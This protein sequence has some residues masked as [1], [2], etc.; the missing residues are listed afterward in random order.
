LELTGA[1]IF[2][3]DKW[4]VSCGRHRNDEF[5]SFTSSS[6]FINAARQDNGQLAEFYTTSSLFAEMSDNDCSNNIFQRRSPIGYGGYN[7]NAS[8]SFL[9]IGSQSLGSQLPANWNDSGFLGDYAEA[10]DSSR[11]T[12]FWGQAG[13]IRFWSKALVLDEVREHA[14]NYQSLG[15]KNPLVNFS[16]ANDVTGSFERLRLDLSTDQPVTASN[17]SGN[18]VLIDFSQQLASGS[19]HFGGELLGFEA[20]KSII[21]P[22]RF[23]YSMIS[24][25]YDEPSE[26]NK[27]RVAGFTEGKNLF[28]I[29]G[30][31]APVYEIPKA[32]EPKD[33]ARFA[34]EFSVMQALN[35]DIMKIFATLDSLDNVLGAPELMFAEEY[36]GL[37]DL[38]NI[39]FNRLTDRVNYRN[40]F[41]FFRWLDN[42]F[43]IMI[44][45]LIPRKTNYLGF[46]FIIEQHALERA[47][48]AYGSGDVYL[49]ESQRRNLKGMILLRQLIAQVRK[50]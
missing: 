11:A 23:V 14:M 26:E 46:N 13:F 12:D 25:Y 24:S 41:D 2:N 34:I 50:I 36:P 10:P 32:S 37:Q 17:A 18:L 43:D 47:K 3:G 33:D 38:R 19:T 20:N 35:E 16:F 30:Y 45:Q 15:V 4:Y 9:V 49:G 8:G 22:E 44:E 21:R 48:I 27:V 29:G 31:P 5:G 40:F 42:S 6:Y 28:E 1:N 39:Y 7:L